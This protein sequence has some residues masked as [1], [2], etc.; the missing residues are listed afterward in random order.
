MV[1]H[2]VDPHHHSELHTLLVRPSTITEKG[3]DLVCPIGLHVTEER[4]LIEIKD[5]KRTDL[6][7]PASTQDTVMMSLEM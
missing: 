5:L 7:K 4:N 2:S 3:L 1:G 6:R